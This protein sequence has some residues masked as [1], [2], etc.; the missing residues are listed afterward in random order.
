[1]QEDVYDFLVPRGF[2][3]LWILKN[4]EQSF[5]PELFSYICLSLLLDLAGLSDPILG[6]G[7]KKP[8]ANVH[9]HAVAATFLP[10]PAAYFGGKS[11]LL[12]VA[13]TVSNVFWQVPVL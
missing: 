6:S 7:F 9:V 10:L 12:T 11:A 8:S 2:S 3:W 1:M 5:W 4:P 13:I